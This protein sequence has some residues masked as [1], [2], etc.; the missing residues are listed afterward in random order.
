MALKIWYDIPVLLCPI[1]VAVN[2][3]PTEPMVPIG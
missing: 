3:K 1:K 2:I